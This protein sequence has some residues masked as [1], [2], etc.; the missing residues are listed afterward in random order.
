MNTQRP[1]A[2]VLASVEAVIFDWD[3]TLADSQPLNFAALCQA[4]KPYGAT[5][6][7]DWYWKRLGTSMPDLL[8]EL[9]IEVPV[10][11]V[12]SECRRLIIDG[13]GSLRLHEEVLDIAKAAKAAA[14]PLAVAS[15]G[16]GD[17]VRA[18]IDATGLS[19]WFAT[20]VTREDVMRGKPAPD[21]FLEAA[22]RLVVDP[23]GCLVVEDADEGL[24]AAA[25]AG[26]RAIDVRCG[27]LAIQ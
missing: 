12:V 25:R 21:L 2:Q 15:G 20:V 11:A 10:D 19:S 18:G 8:A 26:M 17:V 22:K 1:D 24:E 9:N 7:R 14:L 16:A 27:L 5:V 13:V 4:L 3:G 6:Q 23:A